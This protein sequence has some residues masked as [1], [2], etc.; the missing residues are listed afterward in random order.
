MKRKTLSSGK[1]KYASL[2]L[3]MLLMILLSLI[4]LNVGA[5]FLERTHG[6][7]LD[8]SFNAITSH[9]PETLR[10]LQSLTRPVKM[11]ALFSRGAEDAQLSALLDRYAAASPLVSWESA[12]PALSP[13]L[14]RRYST[15]TVTPSAD[16][17]IVFCEETGRF[18]VLGPEDYVSLSL[19]PETGDYAYTGWTYERSITSAI[20]YVAADRVPRAVI[21]QGHGELDPET[22]QPFRNLLEANQYTVAFEDLSDAAFT[23]SPEDLLIFFSPLRDLSEEEQR[24]LADFADRGGS[25]LFACDYSDPVSS[26][27]RYETLLRSYGFLPR[28]GIVVAD[29]AD[30]NSYYSGNLLWLLP[31]MCLTDLTADLIA[32]GAD[33][34]LLPGARAFEEPEEGDRNLTLLPVLR[35]GETAFLKSLASGSASLEKAEGDPSG[36]FPLALEARRI[37]SGGYVSRAFIIGCSAALADEQLYTMTDSQQLTIRVLEFLLSL[38]ASDLSI[39]EKTALRPS[40]S[41]GSTTLGSVLL[42]ALPLSVLFA[43]LLTL[44]PRKDR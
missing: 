30:A 41:P 29:S 22:L 38:D 36:A 25:F 21:L 27:P 14:I 17:L 40:L 1:M 5:A 6:L 8:F 11:I 18:R 23:P 10:I 2:S 15:A 28:E 26:M 31:E 44:G 4:L 9:S 3:L 32:S 33:Q 13:A 43:A 19:D 20:R 12:D 34:L 16:S 24:R 39:L 7:Q 37:T 42:V 35:S